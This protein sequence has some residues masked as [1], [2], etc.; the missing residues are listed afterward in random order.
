MHRV[1]LSDEIKKGEYSIYSE[2]YEVRFWK[3]IENGYWEQDDV[4]YY[5]QHKNSNPDVEKRF[6][7]EYPSCKIISITYQ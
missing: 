2:S 4:I 1:L 5:T 6:L 3:P 7:S